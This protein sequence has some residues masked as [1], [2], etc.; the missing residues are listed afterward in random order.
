MGIQIHN[1]AGDRN[2]SSV[3]SSDMR[4][5]PY[6]PAN[7]LG[8]KVLELTSK[9]QTTLDAEKLIDLFSNEIRN[10]VAVDG[11]RY[12][13]LSH[14]IDIII[15][16][17]PPYTCSYQLVIADFNLGEIRFFRRTR[18]SEE[19]T[20]N[21]ENMLCALVYPLRNALMYRDAVRSSFID[22][23]TGVKNRAAMDNALLREVELCRRQG[24]SMS[25]ILMDLDH[26]KHINDQ[27][28]HAAGDTALRAVAQ[29]TENCIRSSDMLFRFGGEEF[30]ILLS[31]T[32]TDGAL[33]LAERV[34]RQIEKLDVVPDTDMKLTVSLGVSSLQENENAKSLFERADKALYQAKQDGRN[35]VMSS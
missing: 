7:E 27:Q 12:Q 3:Y 23:L 35:R 24:A 13:M 26:F 11:L 25:I 33:L 16:D 28:G 15:G 8:P 5:H 22:P 10:D 1:I 29:C 18:F 21:L 6:T 17:Q 30:L 9:L 2:F 31:Y 20:H 4:V 32:R 34:R 14:G 19:E